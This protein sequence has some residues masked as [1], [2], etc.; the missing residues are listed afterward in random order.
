MTPRHPAA[1]P[2]ATARCHLSSKP[3]KRVRAPAGREQRTTAPRRLKQRQKFFSNDLNFKIMFK[4]KKQSRAIAY[5]SAILIG[6]VG[7]L[8]MPHNF[9]I[10]IIG[11]LILLTAIVF[12]YFDKEYQAR[13]IPHIPRWLIFIAIIAI[14]FVY[15]YTYTYLVSDSNAI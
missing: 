15:A 11:R 9:V 3:A 14:T 7:G 8:A 4:I 2:V 12:I 13:Y 6:V 10:T 5:I 1:Q